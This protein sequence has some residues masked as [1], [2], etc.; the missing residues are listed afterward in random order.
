MASVPDFPPI[1]CTFSVPKLLKTTKA[2][3]QLTHPNR[4]VQ[5]PGV[6]EALWL[7]KAQRMGGRSGMGAVIPVSMQRIPQ[8]GVALCLLRVLWLWGAT[9]G[10]GGAVVAPLGIPVAGIHNT[11]TV[12]S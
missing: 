12:N 2:L 3:Q 11:S 7:L 4:G 1:L 9:V 6:H 5:V 8:C 10:G